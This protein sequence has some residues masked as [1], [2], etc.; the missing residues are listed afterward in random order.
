MAIGVIAVGAILVAFIVLNK[1]ATI[2]EWKRGYKL[3]MQYEANQWME[4]FRKVQAPNWQ[5]LPDPEGVTGEASVAQRK[6]YVEAYNRALTSIQIEM[7]INRVEALKQE[8]MKAI[9]NA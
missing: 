9:E 1:L 8:I 6:Q 3:G 7:V 2:A 5:S 4:A